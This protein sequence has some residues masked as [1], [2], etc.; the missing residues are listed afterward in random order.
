MLYS[1]VGKLLEGFLVDLEG[2]VIVNEVTDQKL[3]LDLSFTFL[4]LIKSGQTVA[5][6][7]LPFECL[8]VQLSVS[9]DV[10]RRTPLDRGD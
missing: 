10:F 4:L 6:L 2:S 7:G 8:R 5:G 1:F 9:G 3:C